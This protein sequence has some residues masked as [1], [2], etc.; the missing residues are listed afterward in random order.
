M[1][2]TLTANSA[3]MFNS[4]FFL[5]IGDEMLSSEADK[6]HEDLARSFTQLNGR[7]TEIVGLI[8][9]KHKLLQKLITE[10]EEFLSMS[11]LIF[12]CFFMLSAY[13]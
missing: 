2:Y 12:Y 9:T 11:T 5:L 6:N 3:N 8:D 4:L 1:H 13:L 10:Y 7:W